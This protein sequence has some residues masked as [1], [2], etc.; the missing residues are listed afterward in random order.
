MKYDVYLMFITLGTPRHIPGERGDELP[1]GPPWPRSCGE[2]KERGFEQPRSL[3]PPLLGPGGTRSVSF[4][5]AHLSGAGCPASGSGGRKA[6]MHAGL[7]WRRPRAAGA[8]AG[9][10]WHS[11]VRGEAGRHGPGR[12]V[13]RA[14]LALRTQSSPLART[15]P[16]KCSGK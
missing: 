8:M 2:Q 1:V 13:A 6:G 10:R 12:D 14:R 7:G 5:S 15:S 9:A 4:P 16:T 11:A 3:V